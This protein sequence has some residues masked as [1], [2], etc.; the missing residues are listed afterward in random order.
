MKMPDWKSV[1]LDCSNVAVRFYDKSARVFIK[2]GLFAGYAFWHPAKLVNESYGGLYEIVFNAEKWVFVLKK[3]E[4]EGDPWKTVDQVE[5]PSE[6]FLS[7][8]KTEYVHIPEYL[9]PLEDVQP[10]PELIDN[11]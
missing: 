7:I 1:F 3:T 11:D 5:V 4:K 2:E 6:E 8:F 10:L 9:E